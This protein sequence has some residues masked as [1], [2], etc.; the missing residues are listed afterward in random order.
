VD[1][2]QI[3]LNR[4][5]ARQNW[6]ENQLTGYKSATPL[7]GDA[8]F[9]VYFRIEAAGQ[10]YVLMDAPPEQESCHA[11]VAI[12]RTWHLLGLPVPVVHCFDLDQGFVL[13]SDFGDQQLLPMLSEDTAPRYYQQAFD[14]LLTIQQCPAIADYDLPVFDAMRYQQEMDLFSNWYLG[15]HLGKTLSADQQHSLREIQAQL[16][17]SALSQPQVCV[18]RDYH[19]RN[20]M[21]LSDGRLGI[22]DFQDA[23]RGPVTYD[24]MSLLRDCYIAWSDDQ[25]QR[26]ALTF[27][28]QLLAANML[29]EADPKVF[30]KWCDLIALQRHLKCMGIFA[31]LYYRDHKKSYLQDI[32]RVLGYTR[33]ICQ[34]YPEFRALEALL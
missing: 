12:G 9:R 34:R 6:L 5:Q 7:A 18:H 27:Q 30:L 13:L 3:M 32:P 4:D 15:R 26:W 19:S 10:R 8:S 31:R 33:G 23:L 28:Q 1:V 11:F 22:L 14:H 24:L 21:V 25:W 20:L 29:D 2:K 17:A 16:I